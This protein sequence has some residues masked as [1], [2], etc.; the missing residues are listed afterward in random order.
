MHLKEYHVTQCRHSLRHIRSDTTVPDRCRDWLAR[1]DES[2]CDTVYDTDSY[3]DRRLDERIE[4]IRFDN[5]AYPERSVIARHINLAHEGRTVL[6]LL[7]LLVEF[8][9][10]NIPQRFESSAFDVH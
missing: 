10:R 6:L 1:P 5:A 8:V 4:D 9:G 7:K 2:L 3:D